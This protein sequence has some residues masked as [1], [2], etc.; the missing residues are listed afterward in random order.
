MGFHFYIDTTKFQNNR[1]VFYE[2]L[3]IFSFMEFH[4]VVT[5]HPK[6]TNNELKT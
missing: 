2:I 1:F 5:D 3:S 6:K 4:L